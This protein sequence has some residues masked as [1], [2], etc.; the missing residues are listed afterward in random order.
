M[1]AYDRQARELIVYYDK[2]R[3]WVR[4]E[5]ELLGAVSGAAWRQFASH[6]FLVET[7]VDLHRWYEF[8][9][10][11]WFSAHAV[12]SRRVSYTPSRDRIRTIRSMVERGEYV[13]LTEFLNMTSD[14]FDAQAEKHQAQAYALVDFLKRGAEEV[15]GFTPA[16]SGI[17]ETYASIALDKRSPRLALADA[18]DGVDLFALEA[19]WVEWVKSGLK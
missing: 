18:I 3:E 5:R 12:S 9:L 19:A 13:Y 6:Y 15:K 16:W 7:D 2:D 14:D 17:L 1:T 11:A 4:N 10:A 8:G